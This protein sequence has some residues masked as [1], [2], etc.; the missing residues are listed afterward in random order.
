MS[1]NISPS[2]MPAIVDLEQWQAAMSEQGKLEDD[3]LIQQQSVAAARRHRP[4]TPVLGDYTFVGPD[5]NCSFADLFAGKRQLAVYHFMF[6][7]DWVKGCPHCTEYAQSQGPGINK[8]LLERDAR[9]IFTSR[10]PYEKIAAWANETGIT[11]PWYSAPTAF[12]EEMDFINDSFGDYPGISIFFR[13]DAD[14]IYRTYRSSNSVVETTMPASGLLRM[15]PWGMQER[16]EDS[17]EGF[18][19]RFDPMM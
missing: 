4:M 16:G 2:S 13:D 17:P 7:P 19:Q 6:A 1:T 15:V 18:P 11:V 3:L 8:E 12:S 5:G 14:V 10:A 9:F